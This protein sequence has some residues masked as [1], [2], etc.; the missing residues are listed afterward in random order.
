MIK[1]NKFLGYFRKLTQGCYIHTC[2]GKC[3]TEKRD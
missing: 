3:L 2:F 1:W